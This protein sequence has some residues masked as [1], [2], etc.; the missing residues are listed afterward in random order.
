MRSTGNHTPSLTATTLTYR[1]ILL[2]LV[3]LGALTEGAL[4]QVPQAPHL[5][6]PVAKPPAS[7]APTKS[8]SPLKITT[9][10]TWQELTPAQQLALKPLAANWDTLGE[11]QKQKW[12]ALSV[13]YLRLAPTEQIKLHSRMTEWVALSP[14]Q[15][16][17]AR[18]NFAQSKKLEQSQKTATWE[19]YQTLSPEEKQSLVIL[20]PPK[21]AGA[22]AAAKPVPPQKQAK[23]PMMSQPQTQTQQPV[24]SSTIYSMNPHTLLPNS[25]PASVSAPPSKN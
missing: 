8:A 22:A 3:S 4:A 12:I 14:S 13:S 18:F 16:D 20:A 6:S 2:V 5:L 10:P 17:Q 21:P 11:A 25:K 1:T 19:T 9:K 24:L 15:R 7:M 23:V